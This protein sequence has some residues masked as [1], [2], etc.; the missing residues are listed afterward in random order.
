MKYFSQ[1]AYK[2]NSQ[3]GLSLVFANGSA[4]PAARYHC[5]GNRKSL[6]GAHLTGILVRLLVNF[7]SCLA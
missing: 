4:G 5:F 3:P 6:F 7:G 1:F 2:G